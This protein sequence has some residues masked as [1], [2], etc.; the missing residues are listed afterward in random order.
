V[1]S[2]HDVREC[3]TRDRYRFLAAGSAPDSAF[4]KQVIDAEKKRRHRTFYIRRMPKSY[5]ANRAHV[6]G[7]VSVVVY[8]R[9][10]TCFQ[11]GDVL[12]GERTV[13]AL[14]TRYRFPPGRATARNGQ[15]ENTGF[16]IPHAAGVY[17]RE[18]RQFRLT[19]IALHALAERNFL[20][21][22]DN[23]GDFGSGQS[24]RL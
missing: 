19:A 12:S 13:Q 20:E 24:C 4:R 16:L 15:Y 7:G 21:R 18:V 5:Y 14:S 22:S 23:C 17:P 10:L 6:M 2:P 9:G 3:E 11:S 8:K 1:S